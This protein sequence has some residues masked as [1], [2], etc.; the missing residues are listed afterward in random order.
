MAISDIPAR[1][2]KTITDRTVLYKLLKKLRDEVVA[3]LG[4]LAAGTQA[5]TQLLLATPTEVTLSAGRF[6]VTQSMHRVDTEG[7]AGSND[8][9]NIQGLAAGAL[10][11]LRP[12]NASRN[13]VI[14][15]TGGGTGNI[16][17]PFA[18]PIT[19]AALTDWALLI[20]DGTNL[21][22]IAFRTAAGNGGGAGA[23]IGLLASLTTTEKGTIVGAIN[24]LFTKAT[25][26]QTTAA[27]LTAGA[28]TISTLNIT[29]G[30][31]ITPIRDLSAGTPGAL[32]IT[33]VTPGTPGSFT[34]QSADASDTSIVRAVVHG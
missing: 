1:L 24:E 28:R 22:V 3:D 26:Q 6:T 31:V 23:L 30:S 14:R 9:D 16:R 7:D 10:Y 17:T 29:A 34:I 13:V 19:L 15:D 27:A 25:V 11:L 21:S 32:S 12:E 5:I 8:L 4:A 20:S 33:S 2:A 18:K